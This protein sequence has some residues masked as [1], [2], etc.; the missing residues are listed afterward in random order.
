MDKKQA[1]KQAAGI[2]VVLFIFSIAGNSTT[3]NVI[4]QVVSEGEDGFSKNSIITTET[5]IWEE[6]TYGSGNSNPT[7]VRCD[8]PI[9]AGCTTACCKAQRTDCDALKIFSFL[10]I[11]T[12][13]LSIIGCFLPGLGLCASFGCWFCNMLVFSITAQRLNGSYATD[14]PSCGLYGMESDEPG[15]TINVHG[16]AAMALAILSWVL[17]YAQA[18]LFYSA[19]GASLLTAHG[20]YTPI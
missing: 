8:A 3:S 13:W 6:R 4:V 12:A 5:G 18:W 20:D 16:G 2:G 10:G 1:L 9:R 19:R 7:R 11:I 17:G 15:V 14:G